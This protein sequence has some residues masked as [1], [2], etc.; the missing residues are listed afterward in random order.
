MGVDKKLIF[1]G[2]LK[3]YTVPSVYFELEET[4]DMTHLPPIRIDT[5]TRKLLWFKLIW[6]NINLAVSS[7]EMFTVPS[8]SDA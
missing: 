7:L 6:L 8:D 3:W 5:L 2:M 1:K 4:C